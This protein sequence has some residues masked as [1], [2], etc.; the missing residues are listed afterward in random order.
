MIKEDDSMSDDFRER[1]EKDLEKV[2]ND[3][4]KSIDDAYAA[5][6]KEIMTI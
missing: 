3:V 1:V 2:V 4:M 6:E 5:K